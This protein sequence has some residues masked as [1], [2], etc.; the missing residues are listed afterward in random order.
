M[1]HLFQLRPKA[2]CLF[3]L[4]RFLFVLRDKTKVLFA[5]YVVLKLLLIGRKK[6]SIF[7]PELRNQ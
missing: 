1:C 2:N 5:F 4:G 7:A 3:V 6:L